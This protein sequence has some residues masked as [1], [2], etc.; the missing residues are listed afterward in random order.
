MESLKVPKRIA[1]AV[2]HSLRSGVTP[3][4]GLPY[5]TVG[6]RGEIEA[7]L[8]DLETAADGGAAFR[9][10]VGPYGSGKSFLL[11][12]IRNYAMDRGFVTADCDLSPQRRLL[13]SKG[14]GLATYREL[15]QNLATRTRPEGGALALILDRWI[16][17]VKTQTLEESGLDAQDSVFPALVE[18]QIRRRVAA[19]EG[20]I[21]GFDFAQLLVRY[22]RCGLEDDD[23]T[24]ERVI[25]WFRG[26]YQTKSEAKAAL[27]VTSV[28]SDQDW[29]GYL[30]L[31]ALFLRGAGYKGLLVLIDEL[32]NVYKI[33][34]ALS[35]QNNYEKLLTLYNDVLQGR[36]SHLALIVGATPQ[37]LEDRRRGLYSYEALRSRLEESRFSAQGGGH[38]LGPLIR[39]NPLKPEELLVLTEKVTALHGRL[40]D[41]QPALSQQDRI[42]FVTLELD[43]AGSSSHITPREIIRDFIDLLD[44]ALQHPD[45]DVAALLNQATASKDP[46]PGEDDGDFIDFEV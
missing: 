40:Y 21:H 44:L 3:R 45:G 18:R 29:Y 33:P 43:R 10:L 5:V 19:L 36:A 31:L 24:R 32:V 6:R 13:G 30:K 46:L 7:L 20:L 34:N 23:E 12:V 42:D 38:F 11:Q 2:I 22:Y 25:K 28:I 17:D 1:A 26:E 15:V 37:C 14:Q 16:D 9:L 4:I 8:D 39:L 35:R 41:Y 27:A